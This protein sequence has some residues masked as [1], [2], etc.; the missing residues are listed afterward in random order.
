MADIQTSH[1]PELEHH[2]KQGAAW[3]AESAQG[4]N[5]AALSYC[6]LEFRFAIERLALHYLA[7][8]SSDE[9]RTDNL[10]GSWR[11]D[12]VRRRILDVAGHQLQINR[13]FEFMRILLRAIKIEE[14][15]VA[16]QFNKLYQYWS[17][18]SELCHVTWPLA[19]SMADM[20][21]QAFGTLT[22][23]HDVLLQL[24]GSMGWP[25][26]IEPDVRGIRDRFV[27]GS[28]SED[29]VHAHFER[30]GLWATVTYP[31]GRGAQF[32]GQPLKPLQ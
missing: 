22:E 3:L 19:S 17:D 8:L 9:K 16:P 5:T 6:A 23:V 11:F 18:C 28:I 29:D 1:K 10:A 31:D 20:R 27:A 15:L 7:S 12:A 32:V 25:N 26:L 13:H 4:E 24:V 30:I 21:E 2:V 14:P